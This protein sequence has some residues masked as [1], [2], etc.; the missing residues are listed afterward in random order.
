MA[1]KRFAKFN[2]GWHRDPRCSNMK[3]ASAKWLNAVLWNLCVEHET[4]TLPPYFTMAQLARESGLN[5]RTVCSSL[6]IMQSN[7]CDLIT[8]NDDKSITVH[9]VA[10]MHKGGVFEFKE[11]INEDS[12]GESGNSDGNNT[13][14][15]ASNSDG[16]NSHNLNKLNLNKTNCDLT[17]DPNFKE[18]KHNTEDVSRLTI[19]AT[20]E[21][22]NTQFPHEVHPWIVN[23]L[24][25]V[26]AD[27]L[28]KAIRNAAAVGD[29]DHKFR[30]NFSKMFETADAVKA[31]S[32]SVQRPAAVKP[33]PV[34]MEDWN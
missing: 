2:L 18:P 24:G 28:E 12:D 27:V 7:M 33:R 13:G 8:I 16:N 11:Y 15:S 17:P 5:V 23:L 34:N 21:Y 10:K 31:M 30:K 25:S 22:K 1:K 14:N 3:T 32:D 9:G 29:K 20:T 26:S 19:L 4:E 6:E